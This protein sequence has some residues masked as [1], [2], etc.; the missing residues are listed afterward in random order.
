M[1]NKEQ[2]VDKKLNEGYTIDMGRVIDNSIA[3]F[4]KTIWISGLAVILAVV[5]IAIITGMIT[6]RTTIG[7]GFLGNPEKFST[8]PNAIVFT[9]FGIV[10]MIVNVVTTSLLTPLYA[11]FL[12]I[13]HLAAQEKE[14]SFGDLFIFYKNNK[15]KDLII[16]GFIVNFT[17]QVIAICFIQLGL[18]FIGSLIQYFIT[19][20]VL[21]ATPLIIYFNLNYSK[22]LEK[23]IPLIL[24]SFFPIILLMFLSGILA[25]LGFLALCIGIFFTMPFI[26]SMQYAIFAEVFNI[27]EEK[28]EIDEIGNHDYNS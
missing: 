25:L 5:F 1:E 26:L 13:N 16:K 14:I 4:K 9:T 17:V 21:F 8:N 24:K 15:T 6:A 27:K 12:N 22:A 10:L 18:D 2:Q 3:Y 11:G 7:T 23:S 20:V 28:T 19:T